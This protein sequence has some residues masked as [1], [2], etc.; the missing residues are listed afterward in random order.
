MAIKQQEMSY[1]DFL[2][3]IKNEIEF[4]A[5]LSHSPYF[6][7]LY[8]IYIF[9]QKEKLY[10]LIVN[11]LLWQ[12]MTKLMKDQEFRGMDIVEKLQIIN[13]VILGLE[14]MHKLF[15]AHRDIKPNN[16]MFSKDLKPKIVDLGVSVQ[17][18]QGETQ[19]NKI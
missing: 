7:K 2:S 13:E 3:E 1:N 11:E 4:G 5:L 10:L 8:G 12:D 9:P 18:P 15:I 14:E 19:S 17:L 16:I 6:P